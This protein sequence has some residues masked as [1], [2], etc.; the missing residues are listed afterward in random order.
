MNEIEL[1]DAYSRQQWHVGLERETDRA[2]SGLGCIDSSDGRACVRASLASEQRARNVA[3]SVGRS[4][5]SE[6]LPSLST[7]D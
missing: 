6:E 4:P 3:S 5:G 2:P 1:F 7:V